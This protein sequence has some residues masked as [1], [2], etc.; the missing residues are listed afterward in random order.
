MEQ[1]KGLT[2]LRRPLCVKGA[3]GGRAPMLAYDL[4]KGKGAYENMRK[5]VLVVVSDYRWYSHPY[6]PS[7]YG[8]IRTLLENLGGDAELAGDI[9]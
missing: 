1:I 4:I 2:L 7:H 5:Q 9:D 6:D 8:K 3:T